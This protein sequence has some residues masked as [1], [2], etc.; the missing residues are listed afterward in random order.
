M[1]AIYKIIRKL[2]KL[3]LLVGIDVLFFS[4]YNPENSSPL[5]VV[6][7]FLL[8]IA[9]VYVLLK[10][11]TEV[12]SSQFGLKLPNERKA[13]ATI[14]TVIGLLIAMQSIGQLT[15]KDV[16]A[17]VPLLLLDVFQ[18]ERP[19]ETQKLLRFSSPTLYNKGE[20]DPNSDR[21]TGLNLPQPVGEMPAVGAEAAP[22]PEVGVAS[23]GEVLPLAPAVGAPTPVT[24]P[25][26]DPSVA[27]P[28][29]PRRSG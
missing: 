22:T 27:I 6:V 8:F 23:V 1:S 12:I 4:A 25:A 10:L 11:L 29:P 19:Q 9:T 3:A 17:I 26:V 28:V 21:L 5:V 2:A 14:T 15:V 7:G 13:I 24:M 20:M 16:L 18:A